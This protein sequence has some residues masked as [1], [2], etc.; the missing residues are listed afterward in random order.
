MRDVNESYYNVMILNNSQRNIKWTRVFDSKDILRKWA[1]YGQKVPEKGLKKGYAPDWK[2]P[3]EYWGKGLKTGNKMGYS[4]VW[5]TESVG[6][7]WG[8]VT[9]HHPYI[10]LCT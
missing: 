2:S 5:N 6:W 4:R 9:L 10:I 7:G 1:T 8:K 3:S